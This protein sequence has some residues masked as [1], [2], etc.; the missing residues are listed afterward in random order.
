MSKLEKI[1]IFFLIIFFALSLFQII[2]TFTSTTT[3]I[4]NGKKYRLLVADTPQKRE[5]GLMYVRNL[6]GID[7]M[8]FIYQD[9]EIRGFWNKNTYLDLD[10]Y[11]INDGKVVGETFLPSIDKSKKIVR[12]FS[13]VPVNKVI[14]LKTKL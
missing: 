7:G 11:W 9:S 3:Y 14:E 10:L 4:L 12:F 13:P 6:R 8:I 1:V 2:L 5:K